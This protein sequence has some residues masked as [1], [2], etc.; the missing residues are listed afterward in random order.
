MGLFVG[1]S[2][3]VVSG[4]RVEALAGRTQPD[5]SGD[6]NLRSSRLKACCH[7]RCTLLDY[8]AMAFRLSCKFRML[9]FGVGFECLHVKIRSKSCIMS[10]RVQERS[11]EELCSTMRLTCEHGLQTVGPLRASSL[12]SSFQCL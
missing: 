12:D 2:M 8:K 5:V 7:A 3:V 10:V 1:L 6:E 4:F 11:R 9:G